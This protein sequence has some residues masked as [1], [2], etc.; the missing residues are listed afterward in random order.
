M[1]VCYLDCFSGISGNM[2][3]GALLAAGLPETVL[4]EELAKLNLPGWKLEIKSVVKAGLRAVMV[5]VKTEEAQPSQNFDDIQ[6]ILAQSALAESV[7]RRVLAV[8]RRLAEAEARV[9]GVP[10]EEV[11]FHEVGAVD[12]LIDIVGAVVGLSQLRIGEI[13]CSP[14]PLPRGWVRC[15][16]GELPLPAPAVCELLKGV[17]VY[18]ENLAQELVTPTGAALAVELSQ[19]FGPLP[20]M[21][22]E[23]SGY[24]AGTRERRDRRPNLLRL[25]IGQRQAVEEAQQ[26]ELIETQLDD[27][28]PECW[29]H[30]SAKLLAAGALDCSLIP[31]QMKKG[32][33]GFFIRLIAD[34]AHAAHLKVLLLSETSAIGLCFHRVQRLTLPRATVEL[35]TPWGAVRGKKVELPDGTVR[36]KPE[37]EDCAKLAREHDISLQQI[38]AAAVKAADS[39]G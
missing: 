5:R 22:I 30:V 4:R 11:H 2:L 8:F 39:N 17:P 36:I 31:V 20:P 15:Q 24:G 33:P 37:Y 25:L 32:R 38:Y 19:F 1:K 12:A 9:H 34:P 18:G 14:L 28:N 13:V 3:L 29:P 10:V 26:I 6:S 27:W 7:I 21:A 16:H 23:Q 35:F